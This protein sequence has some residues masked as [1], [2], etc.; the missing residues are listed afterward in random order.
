MNKV[1]LLAVGMLEALKNVVGIARPRL[2][3]E[4]HPAQGCQCEQNPLGTC[5]PYLGPGAMVSK[6][7]PLTLDLDPLAMGANCLLIWSSCLLHG[8]PFIGS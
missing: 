7:A 4:K 1:S 2:G 3:H 6:G 8:A 5:K